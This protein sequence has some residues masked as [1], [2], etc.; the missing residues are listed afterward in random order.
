MSFAPSQ[1][2]SVS[3][4]PCQPNNLNIYDRRHTPQLSLLDTWH[5][6]QLLPRTSLSSSLYTPNWQ[7]RADSY[8]FLLFIESRGSIVALVSKHY[9]G[10]LRVGNT[11]ANYCSSCQYSLG[12]YPLKYVRLW[13]WPSDGRFYA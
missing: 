8:R 5:L 3:N 2:E 1:R 11:I 6:E 13:Y 9:V 7:L 12:Q 4:N 10:D